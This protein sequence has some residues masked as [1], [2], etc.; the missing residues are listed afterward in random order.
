V[1]VG[2]EGITEISG[3]TRRLGIDLEARIQFNKWLWADFDLNLADGRFIDEPEGADY[4][5]IAPRVSSTGGF[6]AIHPAGFESTLRYRYIGDRPANEF[7]TVTALG[8]MVL[9]LGLAY[10]FGNVKV[11]GYLQNLTDRDWNEAQFDTESRLR[12]EPEPVSELHYTPGNPRNIRLGIAL[13][14]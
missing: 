8:S 9:D 3:E 5:P 11:F 10:S 6:T 1:Y 2:D 14:F 12:N 13:Q 7:N 4:I